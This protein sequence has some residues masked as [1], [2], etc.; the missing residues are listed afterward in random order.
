MASS[1][2]LVCRDAI[3][4][5][6]ELGSDS[7][8]T[9]TISSERAHFDTAG[10]Y[11]GSGRNEGAA[12]PRTRVGSAAG[13]RCRGVR[14]MPESD[15]SVVFVDADD[16][17]WENNRWFTKVIDR[18]VEL[19]TGLGVDGGAALLTLHSHFLRV[20]RYPIMLMRIYSVALF[21]MR[22]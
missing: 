18:W 10:G 11:L 16:T 15:D 8:T 19:L 2:P 1:R 9:N 22:M 5:F 4:R 21:V 7:Q 14:V 12:R 6:R 17:L 13:T 20:C 3:V